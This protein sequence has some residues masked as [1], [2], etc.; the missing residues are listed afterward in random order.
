MCKLKE[1][2]EKLDAEVVGHDQQAFDS[3]LHTADEMIID[4][5]INA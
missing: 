4:E 2:R 5:T 1:L 3:F